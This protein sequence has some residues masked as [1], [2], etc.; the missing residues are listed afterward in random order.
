MNQIFCFRFDFNAFCDLIIRYTVCSELNELLSL[1]TFI[2]G[3][4]LSAADIVSFAVLYPHFA[5]MKEGQRYSTLLNV[6]RWF[7]LVQ[8]QMGSSNVMSHIVVAQSVPPQKKKGADK[9]ADKKA[10]CGCPQNQSASKPVIEQNDKNNKKNKK[11]KKKK[12][13]SVECIFELVLCARICIMEI[14]NIFWS[15]IFVEISKI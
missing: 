6:S 2:V 15:G 14:I 12:G 10:K 9:K 1:K 7:D 11:K 13:Q 3:N 5:T 4:A 8:F